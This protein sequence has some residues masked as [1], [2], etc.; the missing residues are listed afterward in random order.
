M[1]DARVMT[2]LEHL[3]EFKRRMMRV[4]VVFLVFTIAAIVFYEPLFDILKAPAQEA[5]ANADGELIF[6]KVTEAWGAVAKVGVIVGF[7][8]SMPVFLWEMMM[9]LRPGLT[10]SERKYLYFLVPLG[11][12]S[13]AIGVWFGFAVLLPPAINFLLTFGSELATPLITIGSYVGLMISMM[14]WMGLIFELPIVMFF[15]AKIRLIDSKSLG[16]QRRWAILAAF[17]L[18]AI[19]TPTFDPVTQSMVAGPIIVLFEAG[20]WLAKLAERGRDEQPAATAEE[21]PGAE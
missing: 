1:N 4:G 11:T 2:V 9:F 3:G 13:F 19:I 5:L 10:P 16:R 18:G 7:S 17:V 8:L 21:G 20:L 12:I 14:F 15:L 6:T